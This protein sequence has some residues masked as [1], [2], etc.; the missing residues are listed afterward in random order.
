VS[1]LVV[2]APEALGE[3]LHLASQAILGPARD[4][5][6][7][8]IEATRGVDHGGLLYGA[9]ATLEALE[10]AREAGAPSRHFTKVALI[11]LPL[12]GESVQRALESGPLRHDPCFGQ[13][14]RE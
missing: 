7:V 8:P 9:P 2:E 10:G 14:F 6:H 4:Q 5:V 3:T 12:T 1:H 11:R 13:D